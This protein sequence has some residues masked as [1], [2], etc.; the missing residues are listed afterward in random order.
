MQC[1][2]PAEPSGLIPFLLFK[3]Q[4]GMWRT[5]LL[6][7]L[8]CGMVNA[9]SEPVYKIAYNETTAPMVPLVKAI[10][11]EMGIT[12]VFE[13]VPSE[14]AI[15]DTNMGVYDADLSRVEGVVMVYPNLRRTNEPLR[16]TELYAY[17]K[18]TSRIVISTSGDVAL[19]SVGVLEGSKLSEEYVRQAH[20]TPD[21]SFSADTFY[22]KLMANRFDIGLFTSTQLLTQRALLA[23]GARRVGPVLM[24]SPSFHILNQKHAD[25][26]PAF[27]AALKK[28]KMDGRY[29]K[30]LEAQ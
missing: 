12:P 17:V 28:M 4:Q 25:L 3:L 26:I 13:L 21:V 2:K 23:Q 15:S 18:N 27:D 29:L 6:I 1:L 9:A 24:S 16:M 22:K 14:R 10:Y 19:Y 11:A 8:A 30:L 7:L 20:I 5:G